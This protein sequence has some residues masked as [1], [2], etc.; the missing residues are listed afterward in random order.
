L[1]RQQ[2]EALLAEIGE[3][4]AGLIAITHDRDLLPNAP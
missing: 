1:P 4:G 2:W 3:R